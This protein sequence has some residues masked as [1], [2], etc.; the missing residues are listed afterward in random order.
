MKLENIE[1]N[2]PI[3]TIVKLE[4]IESKSQTWSNLR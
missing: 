4:P 2:I 3:S 1:N